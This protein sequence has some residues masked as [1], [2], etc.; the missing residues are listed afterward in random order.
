M[1]S[2]YI[3]TFID[4]F[5][6]KQNK[7]FVLIKLVPLMMYLYKLVNAVHFLDTPT[8]AG[9]MVLPWRM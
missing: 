1:W 4:N 6:K 3:G 9:L 5:K 7:L 2:H 8:A